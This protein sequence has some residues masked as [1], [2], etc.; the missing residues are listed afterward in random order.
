LLDK[1][2]QPVFLLGIRP[3]VLTDKVDVGVFEA[4]GRALKYP[5]DQT[6]VIATGLYQIA[7]GKEKADVGSV[8][9]IAD[10]FQNA[11]SISTERGIQ[12]LMMLSVYLGLFNLLPLPA[13]DGGRLVFL[14]YEMVT[15]RRANPKIEAM[16]HMGGIMVLGVLMILVT[17]KD[18]SRF[19]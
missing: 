2:R 14:G 19:F 5:V 12:L 18:C 7:T 8:V 6:V 17:I 3:M 13:L 9:R 16:I 11:F 4:A 15:R 10:E 1:Q